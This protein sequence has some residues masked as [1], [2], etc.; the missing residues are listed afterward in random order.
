MD[1]LNKTVTKKNMMIAAIVNAVVAI[2]L[3]FY[4]KSFS[5]VSDLGDGLSKLSTLTAIYYLYLIVT[6]IVTAASAF[7]YFYKK[8]KD[9][10]ILATF[11]VSV[12]AF[13]TQCINWSTMSMIRSL[14]SGNLMAALSFSTSA[15]SLENME[16]YL[17]ILGY[18]A[19]AVIVLG[20]Y[21]I[22]EMTNKKKLSAVTFSTGTDNASTMQTAANTSEN[23]N[24]AAQGGETPIQ[25]E[26]NNVPEGP[27][28]ME[29]VKGYW[30]TKTGKRNMCIAGAVVLFIF[31]FLI[32]VN[33]F[34]KKSIS[35]T[36]GCELQV[37]GVSGKGEATVTG[38]NIDY[39]HNNDRMKSFV[40]SVTYTV[41]DNGTFK[42]GDKIEAKA[43]YSQET[44]D[45][46]KLNITDDTIT[47]KVKGLT[48]NYEKYSKIPSKLKTYARKLADDY[49][50]D[51]NEDILDDY[52]SN[53]DDD[54]DRSIT[55]AEM[56]QVMYVTS[57][58]SYT[59]NRLLFVYEV[60]ANGQKRTSYFD[61]TF[62]PV[63]EV[64]FFYVTVNNVDS[65]LKEAADNV[66][67]DSIGYSFD[68][69]TTIDEAVSKLKK[70]FSRYDV[71]IVK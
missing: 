24:E 16:S 65:N 15:S 6:I 64:K 53:L 11:I 33:V 4:V 27:S 10:L 67:F 60:K 69:V 18:V 19:Y 34:Q 43:V 28:F 55:S 39:D 52:F 30:E 47:L 70:T 68:K 41:K 51:N 54:H 36:T 22:Y 21:V 2:L 29:K 14:S 59:T 32:Y 37:S 46:L 38:C 44:A 40:A 23:N 7:L 48:E 13:V 26:I 61:D 5:S 9:N 8:Q 12:I 66:S 56:K 49:M 3:L 35:L 62:E 1:F 71:E 50:K 17:N 42:N 20:A 58:N 63:E 31:C 45:S 25:P 57:E